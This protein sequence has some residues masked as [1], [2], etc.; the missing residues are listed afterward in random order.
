M[1]KPVHEILHDEHHMD[2]DHAVNKLPALC[3]PEFK[4]A[5]YFKKTG[6]NSHLLWKKSGQGFMYQ[7]LCSKLII[8][9]TLTFTRLKVNQS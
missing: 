2:T 7:Q 4:I 6:K 1:Q 9:F 3:R 5:D 8:M